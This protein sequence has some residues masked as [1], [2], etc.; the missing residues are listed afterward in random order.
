MKIVYEDI[1]VYLGVYKV[2]LPHCI[3]FLKPIDSSE[4]RSIP[5]RLIWRGW[6]APR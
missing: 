4:V 6:G 1:C 5:Y 2:R 3:Y